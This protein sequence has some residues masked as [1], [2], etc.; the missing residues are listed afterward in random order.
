M[1]PFILEELAVLEQTSEK[2]TAALIFLHGASQS[3]QE[4]LK[5]FKKYFGAEGHPYI[6]C[7]FPTAPERYLTIRDM[8]QRYW[9]DV[10]RT[11]KEQDEVNC[12]MNDADD[13]A[14]LL[15]KLVLEIEESGIPRK[16]IIIGGCSQ[17]GMVSMYAAY[18]RG[19][20]VGGVFGIAA[21]FP[22][23]R[24]C[25][26]LSGSTTPLLSIYGQKDSFIM[27]SVMDRVWQLFRSKKIPM[28]VRCLPNLGHDMD[29]EYTRLLFE[30]VEQKYPQDD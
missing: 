1:A 10:V 21:S 6:K 24:Q 17:G 9:F 2:A 29:I 4:L 22:F 12:C 7:Y 16:R 14:D 27:P 19:V 5:N 20:Q 18:S 26:L 3:G 30:W 13:V 15:E 25:S 23:F 8:T 28:T 11:G